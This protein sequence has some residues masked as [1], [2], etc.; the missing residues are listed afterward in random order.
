VEPGVERR[1]GAAEF[2]TGVAIAEADVAAPGGAVRA[3][4][5]LIVGAAAVGADV[6]TINSV[7]MVLILWRQR[8]H[9]NLA[10]GK[11]LDQRRGLQFGRRTCRRRHG[12]QH[13]RAHQRLHPVISVARGTD[14]RSGWH[15]CR[16]I[17]IVICRGAREAPLMGGGHAKNDGGERRKLHHT[18]IA[19]TI[20]RG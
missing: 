18:T 17:S 5:D 3:V 9:P 1:R 16:E 12:E 20:R 2:S 11:L 4:I 7:A 13:Q 19:T 6:V 14:Y 10:V 15:T 8:R